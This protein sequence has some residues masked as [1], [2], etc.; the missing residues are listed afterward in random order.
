ME[1][2]KNTE[3]EKLSWIILVGSRYSQKCPYERKTGEFE[4]WNDAA[5]AETQG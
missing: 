1:K 4:N 2:K 3:M 5:T